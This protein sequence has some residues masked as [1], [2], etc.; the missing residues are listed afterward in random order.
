MSRWVKLRSGF[1]AVFVCGMGAMALFA[2][3]P[4]NPYWRIAGSNVFRLRAP[5]PHPP[6][7]PPAPLPRVVPVGITTL[8]PGKR[9]LLKIYFPAQRT[10]SAREVACI[11]AVGQREGAIEVLAIDEAAGSIRIKSSGTEMLLTLAN[12]GPKGRPKSPPVGFPPP[13]LP[14]S[15]PQR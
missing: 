4:A 7:P 6:D 8:L 2:D 1:L 5:E 9:A 3:T 12:D 14:P 15:P 13:P 10:E 11:L